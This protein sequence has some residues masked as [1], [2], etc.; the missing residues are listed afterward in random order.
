M[1]AIRAKLQT[2]NEMAGYLP[3]INQMAQ[4]LTAAN[5][6]LPM[7]QD[8]GELA[9][10]VKGKLPEVRQA[11]QQLNT[12]VTNFDQLESG[13]TKAVQ[14]TDQG[15]T[16]VNQVDGTLPALTDFG[17]NAQAAVATTK[18]VVIPKINTAL[19]VVQNATDAGLTLIAAAN[20][21]LSADLTT[22]QQ[23]LQQLDSSKDTAALK[24][25]MAERLTALANRQGKVA[26]NA[27]SLADTLT[28]VQKTLNQLTGKEDHGLDGAIA[29]LKEVAATA[30]AVQRDAEALAKDVPNLSTS[31]LQQRLGVLA[32]TANQF[33]EAA[34]TLKTLD[35]GTSVK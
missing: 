9:T 17:K 35:I 27:T 3:E 13:I 19:G 10:N 34:N 24:Q 28:R 22:L 33:A 2:A 18:D 23:Q 29:K 32:N 7:V 12:V 21:G 15:I 30:T 25:A 26:A 20:T 11:G 4:K 1:P 5:G 8:A 6:Y 14:V 16:V 31:E